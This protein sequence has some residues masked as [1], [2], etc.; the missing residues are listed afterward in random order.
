[1]FSVC[2]DVNMLNSCLKN[3]LK[4][5]FSLWQFSASPHYI[6]GHIKRHSG[7]VFIFN[8]TNKQCRLQKTDISLL[9]TLPMSHMIHETQGDVFKL[10]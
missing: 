7:E 5:D 9:V 4:K 6:L 1:M 3:Q 10:F 8:L 2:Q